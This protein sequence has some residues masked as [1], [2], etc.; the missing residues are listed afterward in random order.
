MPMVRLTRE[1]LRGTIT[2]TVVALAVFAGL[3]FLGTTGSALSHSDFR[4]PGLFTPEFCDPG[5]PAYIPVERIRGAMSAEIETAGKPTRHKATKLVLRL[6]TASGK[7][8]TPDDLLVVHTERLHLMWFDPGLTDYSHVHPMPVPGDPGAWSFEF[9]PMAAGLYRGFVDVTPRAT[10]RGLYG[11]VELEVAPAASTDEPTD[12]VT[13]GPSPVAGEILWDSD[14]PL[15]AR[16]EGFTL[17]LRHQDRETAPAL[18][19]VMDSYAHLVVI[20]PDREGF[21]HV[22]PIDR[23]DGTPATEPGSSMVDLRFSLLVPKPGEY[24][25]FAQVRTGGIDHVLAFPVVVR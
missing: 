10:A 8:I 20:D 9:L 21:A 5:A 6:R 17:R 4:S 14:A 25:M 1:E 12:G 3:R 2:V 16:Q 11:V 22:H 18:E 23:T 15:A 13:A 24:R 19:L 7:P